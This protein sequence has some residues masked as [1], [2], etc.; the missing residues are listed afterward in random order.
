MASILRWNVNS[1]RPRLPDLRTWLPSI[2]T[3][4]LA[5]QET[6]VRSDEYGLSGYVAY[7]SAAQR[8][9][10]SRAS[11]YVRNDLVQP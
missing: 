11:M 9:N 10:K 7:N 2:H 5:L 8:S 1:L 3:D 4:I 6:R